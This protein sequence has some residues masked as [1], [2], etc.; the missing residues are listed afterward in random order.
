M[1]TLPSVSGAEAKE[2]FTNKTAASKMSIDSSADAI[3]NTIYT[4][5]PETGDDQTTSTIYRPANSLSNA[6]APETSGN[7]VNVTLPTDTT[8]MEASNYSSPVGNYTIAA[9]PETEAMQLRVPTSAA[10][11]MYNNATD[12]QTNVLHPVTSAPDANATNPDAGVLRNNA[13]KPEAG[14]GSN[15]ASNASNP[16]SQATTANVTFPQAD[17]THTPL[18]NSSENSNS[19]PATTLTGNDTGSVSL[20]RRSI[21]PRWT[22]AGSRNAGSETN[23]REMARRGS[24][25]NSSK[26]AAVNTIASARPAFGGHTNGSFPHITGNGP[27]PTT[28]ETQDTQSN[29]TGLGMQGTNHH[30]VDSVGDGTAGTRSSASCNSSTL[31]NSSLVTAANTQTTVNAVASESGSTRPHAPTATPVPKTRSTEVDPA[32]SEQ[33]DLR[34][35]H[36]LTGYRTGNHATLVIWGAERVNTNMTFRE[37]R[38]TILGRKTTVETL[39]TVSN[40]LRPPS[41][42]TALSPEESR[43]TVLIKI[44]P[45]SVQTTTKRV[46]HTNITAPGK[47]KTHTSSREKSG[48]Q[49][50]ISEAHARGTRTETIPDPNIAVTSATPET[51]VVVINTTAG[52]NVTR[53]D[54]IGGE[55]SVAHATTTAPDRNRT[56]PNTVGIYTK[57]ILNTTVS[58]EANTTASES[59][60]TNP[61]VNIDSESTVQETDSINTNTTD[62]EPGTADRIDPGTLGCEAGAIEI[63]ASQ[64]INGNSTAS[65]PSVIHSKAKSCAGNIPPTNTTASNISV[66]G[67]NVSVS[68]INITHTNHT[69]NKTEIPEISANHTRVATIDVNVTHTNENISYTSVAP[70]NSSAPEVNA[71]Q[72][73]AIAP[74]SSITHNPAANETITSFNATAPETLVPNTI[75]MP[76]EPNMMHTNGTDAVLIH[77]SPTPPDTSFNHTNASVLQANIT[78]TTT[79]TTEATITNTNTTTHDGNTTHSNT[80]TS[81]TDATHSNTSASN[82]DT[83]HS[84]TTAPDTN[85]THSNTTPDTDT[86][87]NTA[88]DTDTTHS[89]T[90]A[91][92]TNTTHSNTTFDTNTPHSNTTFDTNTPHSNTTFDTNTPHSNTTFDTNTT[93][94]N[95]T[96][97]TNT[98]HSNTTFDTNT[99]HSNGRASDTETNQSNTTATD[100]ET[101]HCNTTALDTETAHSNITTPDTDTTHSNTNVPDTETNRTNTTA[102]E[103]SFIQTNVTDPATI[104]TQTD[105]KA[106]DLIVSVT[107]LVNSTAHINGNSTE[108]GDHHNGAAAGEMSFIHTNATALES[109]DHHVNAMAPEMNAMQNNASAKD[110]NV[111][112]TN[113]SDPD[114]SITHSNTSSSESQSQ[115]HAAKSE[116]NAN[117]ESNQLQSKALVFNNSTTSANASSPKITNASKVETITSNNPMP[118]T[119]APHSNA[120][121]PETNVSHSYAPDKGLTPINVSSLEIGSPQTNASAFDSNVIDAD[122]AVIKTKSSHS[123]VTSEMN[124]QDINTSSPEAISPDRNGT[125]TKVTIYGATVTVLETSITFLNTTSSEMNITHTDVTGPKNSIACTGGEM[126]INA[127]FLDANVTHTNA[128]SSESCIVRPSATDPETTS[129]QIHVIAQETG[130]N[131]SNTTAPESK[132]A[133]VK[134]RAPDIKDL[135]VP[136]EMADINNRLAAVD[137]KEVGANKT[138]SVPLSRTSNT[139][140]PET[141]DHELSTT[142]QRT[143]YM[144]INAKVRESF[145]IDSNAVD[146]EVRDPSSYVKF[147]D[148]LSDH[149]NTSIRLIMNNLITFIGQNSREARP[150]V[151]TLDLQYTS[152]VQAGH[153]AAAVQIYASTTETEG[154]SPKSTTPETRDNSISIAP[155]ATD[156]ELVGTNTLA[157]RATRNI[158]KG[159]SAVGIDSNRAIRAIKDNIAEVITLA[160]SETKI[161]STSRKAANTITNSTCS[162]EANKTTPESMNNATNSDPQPNPY[163]VPPAGNDT[164]VVIPATTEPPVNTINAS[165]VDTLPGTIDRA[166]SQM[167]DVSFNATIVETISNCSGSSLIETI[168]F[169]ASKNMSANMSIG[170][171]TNV[172]V[173]KSMGINANRTTAEPAGIS[174]DTMISGAPCTQP[175]TP[176]TDTIDSDTGVN[177]PITM[178]NNPKSTASGTNSTTPGIIGIS[179]NITIDPMDIKTNST[180]P[181]ASDISANTT[182]P[183][184]IENNSTAAETSDITTNNTTGPVDVET[185]STSPATNDIS[186]NTT[187]GPVDVETNSTSPA[188]NDISNNTTT[189]PVDIETNSTRPGTN[190]ISNN[191][192]TEPVD[193]ETNSTR[194]RPGDISTNTTTEPMDIETNSTTHGTSGISTNTTTPE[195][196]CCED[197]VCPPPPTCDKHGE[198]LIVYVNASDPCCNVTVCGHVCSFNNTYMLPGQTIQH[199]D[200]QNC[201]T[202]TCTNEISSGGFLTLNVSV[203]SCETACKQGFELR[204]S[205]DTNVCCSECVQESCVYTASPSAEDIV[206]K[207]HQKHTINNC[208]HIICKEFDG[209]LVTE[210]ESALCPELD[211]AVCRVS[212]GEVVDDTFGCCRYC[213]YK[214]MISQCG[215]MMKSIK[216][217][218]GSCSAQVVITVCE[219]QCSSI[220]CYNPALERMATECSCC[221]PNMAKSTEVILT[222]TNGKTRRHTIAEPVSCRCRMSNCTDSELEK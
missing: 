166:S 102:L 45:R 212:G 72:T 17:R 174:N 221:L 88:P 27:I 38:Q 36:A 178:D 104:V 55:S 2:D 78:H 25:A 147:H 24:N 59:R 137:P 215:T 118:E 103:T 47:K 119:N 100:T 202:F 42:V 117:A 216:L 126:S 151:T 113:S 10:G 64:I 87:H 6:S 173:V 205:K 121:A 183:V 222:C 58:T 7:R 172:T 195:T 220:T 146:V 79:N 116:S 35:P 14:K 214:Q 23:A 101:T 60:D 180:S 139:S 57:V 132:N 190:D 148:I 194:P 56:A 187:T 163:A 197:R 211:E 86:T 94:S 150:N 157:A 1:A 3:E 170:T 89:N 135:E 20:E 217:T 129:I 71:T 186:N 52:N 196:L 140:S 80:T 8:E 5:K 179:T 62:I 144:D 99:T 26:A 164:A 29:A 70:T 161:N 142:D 13:N 181:G 73:H 83:A 198:A 77:S 51:S 81:D 4:T 28:A 53:H 141:M 9:T 168:G 40:E 109:S 158:R 50:K 156:D 46:R 16:E 201:M 22:A 49:P 75:K 133:F 138:A 213:I 175:K 18:R 11:D 43:K 106:D 115:N 154:S 165:A 130:F 31:Q 15:N 136:G 162:K 171:N 176:M 85:T 114:I 54:A 122:A 48:A 191:T 127:T 203:Q 123:N 189:G 155:E 134:M 143:E 44:T 34:G 149:R 69:Y 92:D 204:R 185:N 218:D 95:T 199:Q 153:K 177:S 120:S 125:A 145:S 131:H 90:T 98:P 207:L 188:T 111:T 63:N 41:L 37:A 209:Y 30:L 74:G 184:D 169:V 200:S 124:I 182:E 93:H 219:G 68:D 192:T 105:G 128:T 21:A 160:T 210:V 97:D 12:L 110:T 193:I 65:K 82:T 107:P 96:F 108:M 167:K 33:R 112:H 61:H 152:P 84:N 159:L 67:S 91:S 32:A 66:A 19:S 39:A 76:V 206:I 208:T